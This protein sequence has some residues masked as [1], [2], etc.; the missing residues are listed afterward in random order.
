MYQLSNY[1]IVFSS[2]FVQDFLLRSMNLSQIP[3]SLFATNGLVADLRLRMNLSPIDIFRVGL[4]TSLLLLDF[5]DI[6]GFLFEDF[7][8]HVW[9]CSLM[10]KWYATLCHSVSKGAVR[11]IHLRLALISRLMLAVRVVHHVDEF[12]H[13]LICQLLIIHPIEE[14]LLRINFQ[15]LLLFLLQIGRLTGLSHLVLA[16]SPSRAKWSRLNKF[17]LFIL[18]KCLLL[19]QNSDNLGSFSIIVVVLRSFTVFGSV[20]LGD[21]AVLLLLGLF[22][23]LLSSEILH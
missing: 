15:F 1:E 9:I 12:Y 19:L 14:Q 2:I 7:G 16:D 11:G 21:G 8:D 3:I 13:L 18:I 17:L 4:S 6:L 22:T 10:S 20:V 23:I 5:L